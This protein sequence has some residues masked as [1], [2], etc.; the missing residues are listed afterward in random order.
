MNNAATNWIETYTGQQFYPGNPTADMIDILDIAHA[1]SHQCR[2]GGHCSHF[3][4]VAE[5]CVR[6]A[7]AAEPLG[8]RVQ[9]QAL[10]HDATE[11]YVIDVPRPVKPFLPGYYELEARVAAVI[12]EKFG[13]DTL[14][15]PE[16]MAL[17]NRI[18][19]DERRSLFN[20][21]GHDWKIAGEPLNCRIEGWPSE[22]AKEQFLIAFYTYTTT[23]PTF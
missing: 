15:P 1:L 23:V 3:Y 6:V 13:L 20:W 7:R 8:R 12:A 11:A 21:S 14:T 16:V 19:L 17:D 4:S 2:F 10:L 22:V 9:L 5:H 18:L